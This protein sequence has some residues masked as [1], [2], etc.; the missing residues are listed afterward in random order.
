ML[1]SIIGR[2]TAYL[3]RRAY[4][5]F[6]KQGRK[7]LASQFIQALEQDPLSADAMEYRVTRSINGKTFTTIAY[8]KR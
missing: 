2:V 7:H 1:A 6:V 3:T 4:H 5:K 8:I